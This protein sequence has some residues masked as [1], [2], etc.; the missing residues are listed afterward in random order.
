MGRQREKQRE[1]ERY[2]EKG[3]REK[4][5]H[6]LVKEKSVSLC[7]AFHLHAWPYRPIGLQSRARGLG[8]GIKTPNAFTALIPLS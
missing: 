5:G 3:E 6:K 4:G 8:K 2:T 1:K 7:F